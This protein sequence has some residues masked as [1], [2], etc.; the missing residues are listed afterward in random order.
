[1]DIFTTLEPDAMVRVMTTNEERLFHKAVG[2]RIANHR[3]SQHMTQ[4]QL[5]ETLGVSQQTV[6]SWEVGRR[7]VAIAV[8][9][10]LA[11]ALATSVE[12]LIGVPVPSGKRGPQPRLLQQIERIQR[13]PRPQQRFVMQMIDTALQASATQAAE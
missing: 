13:L 8:L 1:M 11:R 10:H 4:V 12:Q 7:G 6:A 2:T 5:A 9:P 3:N